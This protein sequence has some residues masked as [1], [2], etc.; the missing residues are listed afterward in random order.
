M[1]SFNRLVGRSLVKSMCTI[2]AILLIQGVA[3]G[4]GEKKTSE[5]DVFT[6]EEIVVTSTY[7]DTA[8]MD[9]P[10]A[11]NALDAEAITD[12]GATSMGDI[13]RSIPGLNVLQSTVSSGAIS[14]RGTMNMAASSSYMQVLPVS[15][16]YINDTPVTGAQ[17]PTRQISGNMFDV[18]RFELLKGP[19]GTLYGE[20][21]MTGTLRYVYNRPDLNRYSFKF[22]AMTAL[23]EESD[24]MSYRMDMMA[25]IP[26]VPDKLALRA[27]GFS[28]IQAGWID[29][30]SGDQDVNDVIEKGGRIQLLLRPTDTLSL[31]GSVYNS[32]QEQGGPTGVIRPYITVTEPV[33]GWDVGAFDE[34]QL[35][36]L[37]AKITFPWADLTSITSY[38][39][40]DGNILIEYGPGDGPYNQ[41]IWAMD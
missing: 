18:E 40:R 27:V 8:E 30:I 4:Q 6:L 15:A 3:L 9:T 1:I 37:T 23:Q 36:N 12:I 20:G 26:L 29:R 41:F 33:P 32:R 21:S 35:Y 5:K 24:D 38:L 14:I 7:R 39:D 2:L 25:N 31:L 11:I 10:I 34:L 17:G 16:V 28:G 19:Q 22:N 13:F